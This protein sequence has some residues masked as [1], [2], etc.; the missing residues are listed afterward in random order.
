MD[1][2]CVDR[3]VCVISDDDRWGDGGDGGV[4]GKTV[5]GDIVF[6]KN[7]GL[8]LVDDILSIAKQFEGGHIDGGEELCDHKTEFYGT[9]SDV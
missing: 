9:N 6:D 3:E 1:A 4:V 7:L 2:L 8:G 5:L